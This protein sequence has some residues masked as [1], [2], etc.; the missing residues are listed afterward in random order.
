[1]ADRPEERSLLKNRVSHLVNRELPSPEPQI[2][3]P[4]P[5]TPSREIPAAQM[6]AE[7]TA[8]WEKLVGE[9]DAI[10][11]DAESGKI[12]WED[13]AEKSR[14]LMEKLTS[15]LES[16]RGESP[17]TIEAVR[18]SRISDEEAERLGHLGR[19]LK[20]VRGDPNRAKDDKTESD[21]NSNEPSSSEANS[22]ESE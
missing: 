20:D 11:A 3:S 13:S 17:N 19:E 4:K 6:S 18:E 5:R 7:E 12:D 8:A 22:V 9:L 2:P 14:A 16:M 21:A 1:V 15:Q 10:Q